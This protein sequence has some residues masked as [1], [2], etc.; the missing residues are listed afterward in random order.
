MRLK[1]RRAFTLVELLVV[2]AIIAL[3]LSILLPV[4]SRVRESANRA[5]CMSNLRNWG[6]AASRFA[7]DNDGLFPR[8]FI[9]ALGNPQPSALEARALSHV[10]YIAG[11]PPGTTP[12]L[13]IYWRAHGTD[14]STWVSNGLLGPGVLPIPAGVFAS[15]YLPPDVAKPFTCP[16]RRED[17]GVVH[18]DTAW[19]DVISSEYMYIGGYPAGPNASTT[20]W[21]TTYSEPRSMKIANTAAVNCPTRKPAI[22]LTDRDISDR[23]LAIDNTASPAGVASTFYSNHGGR[24]VPGG[25]VPKYVNVLYG[26]GHVAGYGSEYFP[27]PLNAGNYSIRHWSGSTPNYFYWGN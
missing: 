3:L 2:I 26:D 19:G 8:G 5:A 6:Q 16:S 10:S 17:I 23:I 27:A 24:I 21:A 11:T 1:A 12:A 7:T 14:F 15:N 22:A 4:L 20:S 25:Y 13:D 9:H 18:G